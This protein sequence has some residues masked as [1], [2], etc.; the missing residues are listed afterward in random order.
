M[1]QV[2]RFGVS[3]EANLL[4]RFDRIIARKGYTNR[5]EALRDLIRESLVREQWEAGTA[6][7]VGTVTLVYSHDVPDLADK[8]TDL[9]H[10]HYRT[11]VSTLHV[12]LDPHHCLEVLVLR[13]KA[14]E[15]KAI[16]DRLIGTRGVKHGTFSATTE[17]RALA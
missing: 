5:S 13:G 1:S 16:A 15:L 9:Q 2:T 12:H 11:I 7:A 6:E 3:L 4:E 17:G 10:A 14:R 8:L